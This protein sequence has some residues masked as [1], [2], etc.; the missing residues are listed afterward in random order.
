[1]IWLTAAGVF[2]GMVLVPLML[3]WAVLVHTTFKRHGGPFLG[4]PKRRLLWAAPLVLLLHPAVYFVAAL[5]VLSV[6]S[7]RGRISGGWVW[8]IVG[9]CAYALFIGTFTMLTVMK[10]RRRA[11]AARNA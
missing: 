4:E 1:M 10:V 2:L 7:A 8:V 11:R 5:V 9:F 3:R 6:L